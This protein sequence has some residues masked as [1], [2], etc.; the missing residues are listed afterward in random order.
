MT[1]R[2]IATTRL[3]AEPPKPTID[4]DGLWIGQAKTRSRFVRFP[5]GELRAVDRDFDA[6]VLDDPTSIPMSERSSNANTIVDDVPDTEPV[7]NGVRAIAT[8]MMLACPDCLV[9]VAE[10]ARGNLIGSTV[11]RATKGITASVF[12]AAFRSLPERAKRVTFAASGAVSSDV[13]DAATIAADSFLVR[14]L[15]FI[16]AE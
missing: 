15:G 13:R 5:D 4:T 12:R 11:T 3:F 6:G 8:A 16:A 7:R 9:A 1:L 14:I 2:K 10:D